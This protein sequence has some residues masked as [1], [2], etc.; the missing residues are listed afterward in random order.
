MPVRHLRALAVTLAG[1]VVAAG[2]T[3][4]A[5]PQAMAL[6][7]PANPSPTG[8]QTGIPTFSWDRVDG[9]T[10]YDFQIST[11]VDFLNT[12]LVNA[13][14]VQRQYVPKIQLPTGS[15]LY[16]RVRATG[17]GENWTVTPFS[18]NT[19]GAP[20]LIGPA[21]AASLTQPDN[22]VVLSWQP[23][24]GADSYDVQYGTDPNFVDQT[25]TKN[26]ESSSYVVP[27]QT[28]GGYFWRVRGVLATGVF[29]AWS[30]GP[31]PLPPARSYTVNG[32]ANDPQIPPTSP[33]D[34][35]DQA[36]TDVV[37]DWE[38]IKGAKSYELQISTDGQFPANSHTI[39]VS[40]IY[41]TRYSPPKT[42]NNDQYL[43]RIR[44]TDAAGFQPDWS[45]RPVWHFKR[46]WPDQPTLLYPTEGMTA[47]NPFYFQW[48]PVK[49][50][51]S[52]VVQISDGA[53]FPTPAPFPA[54]CTTTHTTL[55]YGDGFDGSC[56]PNEPGWYSWR[57]TARDEFGNE[58]PVTDGIAAQ[59]GTFYYQGS[60]VTTT[61]PPSGSAYDNPYGPD[62]D[63]G[64]LLTWDP[65]PGADKY[66][67]TVTGGLDGVDQSYTT[68]SLSLA[69]RAL[70]GGGTF[71]WDVQTVDALGTVGAGHVTQG[72]FSVAPPP[73]IPDPDHPGQFL[74]MP[75][76]DVLPA[77]GPPDPISPLASDPVTDYYRTPGFTWQPVSWVDHYELYVAKVGNTFDKVGNFDWASGADAGITHLTPGTYQWFVKAVREDGTVLTGATASYNII[78]LPDIPIESYKAALGGN[79]L[80]GNANTAPD[81]CNLKVPSNCQNLRATPVLGWDEPS[82][83]V[84]HYQV[85]LSRD[86]LVTNIIETKTIV[87]TMYLDRDAIADGQAG[88]AYYVVVLPCLVST[89]CNSLTHATHAYNKLTRPATLISPIDGAQVQD[90]VTLTWD[91]YLVSE[92]TG[93]D[94]NTILST[95]GQV[96]ADHYNVQTAGDV[97]FTTRVTTTSVDQTTFTSFADTYPEG[98]TW[99][100]VQAVDRNDNPLAWSAPRSFLKKSPV[101]QLLLP[102]DGD[103]VPGD[104]T[105]SWQAQAYA[106]SYDLEVY[107]GGDTS[108]NTVNR[109]INATTDRIQ[110]VL[111]NLDP[112]LGPYAWRV[113]RHDGRDR[114]GDWS[115]FRTFSVTKPGVSLIAPVD[116]DTAVPPS[117]QLFT[118]QPVQ[119]AKKYR[120]ERRP[121][122]SGSPTESVDTP[123]TKWAP[124]AAIAGG[125]WQW[126]VT[127]YDAADNLIADSTWLHPFSVTDTPVANVAVSITGS[128]VVDSTLTL[129]PAQWNMPNNVLNITYMWF[130]GA[131]ATGVTGDVYEV[132]SADVGK[133]ITVKATATRPGYKTGTSTSNTITGAQAGA[134]IA[135]VP[136][137]VSGTGLY[138]S[139]LTLQPPTWDVP[140]TATSY[141]WFR[142]TSSVSGQTGTSYVVGASDI[143]KDI[144]VKAT[145]TKAGYVDGLSVSNAVTAA[146]NP[147]PTTTTPI[148]LTGTG[149]VGSVLTMTPPEWDTAGV[150]V[151]YQWFR[152][153]SS[154]TNA[155]PTYTVVSGDVGKTISVKA[156]AAKTGYVS[157][158]S[159]SN[160]V[161]A[162]QAAAVTPTRMPAITGVP[163]AR[164]KLT[165]D[166]GD[167][168]GSGSKSYAYQWFVNGEAVAKETA[169]TYTVR[170]R[171]AGL[172]VT[173]RVTMTTSGVTPSVAT[174]PAVVISKLESETSVTVAK[175][176]IT[177][178][179]RAVLTI[180]VDLIDFG[181]S[182][183][184]VQVKD[185][186]KVVSLTGL[187][188]GKDGKLTIRLKKLKRG[189]HKLVVSYLGSVSTL[190]SSAKAVTIKVIKPK[191]K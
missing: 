55:T 149:A 89:I 120:F 134:P 24:P 84:G 87:S 159:T 168:P 68:A 116:N 147:A 112:S 59:I 90:D 33:P 14:T 67:V 128:G 50:A 148:A 19:V 54:K 61:G 52:Y 176:K 25:T 16:W 191:K 180:Q 69:P 18:R 154:F 104:F 1:A 129:I 26:V 73:M 183:G 31:G 88:S 186:T 48:T 177:Q 72:S 76:P 106:A 110:F 123:T 5:S 158:V 20:T 160:G 133:A 77:A 146:L 111:T 10:T 7:S 164:E 23:V 27:L 17:A 122:T 152:D 130:R 98:T 13:T 102:A 124:T 82:D 171:D 167:W 57:V 153:A 172:P 65:V 40:T 137:V 141:Q 150:T 121:G 51:S 182:L 155:N 139:T 75:V 63:S 142:G 74:L 138:G 170:T 136:V 145:G 96:E 36:L 190:A 83:Y 108:G 109:V 143:G 56:W 8:P 178:R 127:A 86:D 131:T 15:Q 30:G 115:P 32:L 93:T 119:G 162:T 151:T 42:L 173:V 179:Q 66:L 45:T 64:P 157:G 38:P 185:G 126:R 100:R 101:P 187:Q 78:G 46:N 37:L 184:Q 29:T 189:K 91:D 62:T 144:T 43:W 188:T 95:P 49:H 156:T 169:K 79:Q 6:D 97:N 165:A 113:R 47:P 175:R 181:V 4:Y 81:T 80:T 118:W 3:V 41:G 34:N 22:P 2:L 12:P 21:D 70:E 71:H 11:S 85:V 166:V 53:G 58:E 94:A 132:T 103:T 105:L 140:G 9:A 44:A 114:L 28:P 125:S 39:T 174:T 135:S 107:K 117:D 35:A 60:L 92:S 163:A 99:W 161:L